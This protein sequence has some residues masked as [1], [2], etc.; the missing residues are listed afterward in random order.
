MDYLLK[1]KTVT[2]TLVDHHILNPNDISLKPFVVQIFDHR[3]ID[4][5]CA[6]NESRVN[7]RIEQV[8]SCSTIIADEILK[9]NKDFL[10]KQLAYLIYGKF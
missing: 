6:W 7:I 3:P 9:K 5:T 10:F 2:V 4:P 1:E 8:G